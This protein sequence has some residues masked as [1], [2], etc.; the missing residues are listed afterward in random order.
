MG[1]KL[2]DNFRE[3][4]SATEDYIE[5]SIS[6]HKLDIFKKF[7]KGV[8]AGSYQIILGFFLLISLLFLSIAISIYVGELLDSIALGYL[9]VGAFYL[10]LMIILS[11]FLKKSL[12]KILVKKASIQFFNYS[13]DKKKNNHEGLQ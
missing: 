13:E 5:A 6:Y 9:I 12:E 11:F 1:K 4:T 10:V 7:M 8:V 3:F 2:T